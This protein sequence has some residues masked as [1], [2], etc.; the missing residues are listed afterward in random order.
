MIINTKKRRYNLFIFQK[1]EKKN[2]I[3]SIHKIC[4]CSDYLFSVSYGYILSFM[5]G[6]TFAGCFP[7]LWH[8]DDLTIIY[9]LYVENWPCN[10]LIENFDKLRIWCWVWPNYCWG[11][12][13]K[14]F[15]TF[16]ELK[17]KLQ[18]SKKITHVSCKVNVCYFWSLRV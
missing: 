2:R 1:T 8:I 7:K 13:G 5:S 4:N 9:Y 6:P 10:L 14:L 3:L 16:F 12:F 15:M 18:F 17:S 11:N